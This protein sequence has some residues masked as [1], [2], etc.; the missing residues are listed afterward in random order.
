[1]ALQAGQ[2]KNN[3][4]EMRKAV[5]KKFPGITSLRAVGGNGKENQPTGTASS[6][7]LVAMEPPRIY[8][9][10]VCSSNA[11]YTPFE[12]TTA[13][14]DSSLSSILQVTMSRCFFV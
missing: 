14:P 1:M 7:E 4:D 9:F 3:L 11:I 10:G 2:A 6:T 5:A 13:I 12:T 8:E